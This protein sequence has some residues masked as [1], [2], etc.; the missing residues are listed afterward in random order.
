VVEEVVPLLDQDQLALAYHSVTT[1]SLIQVL[2]EWHFPL[3]P[4]GSAG[5]AVDGVLAYRLLSIPRLIRVSRS[6]VRLSDRS[7]VMTSDSSHSAS[8]MVPFR[9]SSNR[10]FKSAGEY[11]PS[12]SAINVRVNAHRSQPTVRQAPRQPRRL[13]RKDQPDVPEADLGDKLLEPQPP[14]AARP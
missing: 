8:D 9:P 4:C 6:L 7:F 12:L 3:R 11:T 2:D 14:I 1:S 10:S 13:Q 5:R